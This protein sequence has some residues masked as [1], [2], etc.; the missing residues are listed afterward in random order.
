VGDRCFSLDASVDGSR[1]IVDL[2]I[3]GRTE[4][5]M[6]GERLILSGHLSDVATGSP[7][8][9]EYGEA[10]GIAGT[11]YIAGLEST[12]MAGPRARVRAA[13]ATRALLATP[14]DLV[15]R[16]KNPA[17]AIPL[18]DLAKSGDFL[19]PLT[20]GRDIFQ[21]S[22]GRKVEGH[23]P[24]PSLVD[25]GSEFSRR[26][27]QII[28]WV[29]WEPKKRLKAT[30]SLRIYDLNNKLVGESRPGKLDLPPGPYSYTYWPL[31]VSKIPTATY[32]VDVVI[33]AEPA[34]RGYLKISE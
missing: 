24:V 12:G 17:Q 9:N 1:V 2:S 26:D 30:Y 33:G 27:G 15:P 8:L 29:M 20:A 11:G 28:L 32:R 3:A 7:L 34:W 10:I 6:A 23:G 19:P 14:T 13:T 25:Q 16:D 21:A 18:A 5:P 4:R 31:E 22:F